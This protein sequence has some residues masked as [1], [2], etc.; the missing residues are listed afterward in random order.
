PGALVAGGL[1]LALA[2]RLSIAANLRFPSLETLLG[3]LVARARP[4]W[5]VLERRMVQSILVGLL[6]DDERLAGDELEPVRRYAAAG[7]AREVR[8]V[9]LAGELATL[10]TDYALT[11]PEMAAAWSRGEGA[12]WQPRLWREVSAA[13]GRLGRARAGLVTQL[14]AE[15]PPGELAG[16]GPVH[17]FG[18]SYLARGVRPLLAR[19]ARAVE[20]RIYNPNPCREFW[21]DAGDGPDDNPVLAAWGRPARE[22]VAALNELDAGRFADRYAEPEA[23]GALGRLQRD[24]LERAPRRG[25]AD[26]PAAASGDQS[27]RILACP[28]VRRELEVIGGAITSMLAADPSLRLCDVAVLLAPDGCERYQ[29]QIGA[30][31]DELGGIAHR[32]LE[33]PLAGESRVVEAVDALL[34]LPLGRFTRAELLGLMVHPAVLARF[35]DVDR[36][37]WVRWCDELGIAHGADRGDHEGTYIEG[38]VYNWDQGLRRLAL[39]SFMDVGERPVAV[40][41]GAQ[42]YVPAQVAADERRSAARFALLAR[43]LLAAARDARER[44]RPLAE[45]AR[46]LDR[47]VADHIAAPERDDEK[48]LERVRQCIRD[49]A[50]LDTGG[51]P[52]DHATARELLREATGRLRSPGGELPTDAVLVAPLGPMRALPRRVVFVA[53]LGAGHF[54]A[55]ERASSLD[56]RAEAPRRAGDVSPRDRDRQAFLEALLAARERLVVSY[57]ARDEETGEELE[58]SPLVHELQELLAEGY[59]APDDAALLVERP[60]LRRWVAGSDP[61]SRRQ[62]ACAE[63]RRDLIGHLGGA[64]PGEAELERALAGRGELARALGLGTAIG[65]KPASRLARASRAEPLVLT[66]AAVRRFLECPLQAW[67]AAVLGVRGADEED[68]VAVSAEPFERDLLA[69]SASLKSVF[70]AHLSAGG[71]PDALERL[72]RE[73]ARRAELDGRAPTGPFARGAAL[74]GM[75]VLASWRQALEEAAGRLPRAEV[76]GFGAVR[77]GEVV[78]RLE[79]PIEIEVAGRPVLL[80]GRTEPV[81]EDAA[82]GS[83]VLVTGKDWS[84]RHWLRGAMD[85][86]ALAAAGAGA[87]AHAMTI[88]T[89]TGGLERVGFAPLDG[90]A[91]RGFLA[92][93]VGE[94]F[95]APHDYL[96]PCEAAL[97]QALGTARAPLAEVVSRLVDRKDAFFSSRGGPLRLPRH[98]APPPEGE[99]AEMIARRFR[100]WRRP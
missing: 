82:I 58:P 3:E 57:V 77:E 79:A 29:A 68:L 91:A 70:L 7:P 39:G 61:V 49:L 40:R 99:A 2:R 69:L 97:P 71:G 96:L 81:A 78:S 16:V 74:R 62:A 50:E 52:V 34:D 86:V 13:A 9:Q 85:A 92:E 98:L 90:A 35:P 22:H 46:D 45:W 27:V 75:R 44:P 54:P 87:R 12:G 19:L 94:L 51:A 8:R 84:A 25:P 18:F 1:R 89:G 26:R 14:F 60:P 33:L 24:I 32:R 53:G 59:L 30:V 4:D 65:E 80:T 83:I 100:L 63:L 36:E 66:L 41:L 43:T 28:G 15:L 17:L 21:E 56:V 93:L 31:F 88:A 67:A 11:R 5:L 42:S 23:P 55:G 73:A 95:A 6:A 47:L 37:D 72:H 48:V 64:V 76:I 38:D 10:F 20:V